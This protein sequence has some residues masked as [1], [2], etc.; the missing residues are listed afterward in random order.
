MHGTYSLLLRGSTLLAK[1]LYKGAM[2]KSESLKS[3]LQWL[4]HKFN[5][6]LSFND[7]NGITGLD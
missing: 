6:G 4:T 5:F 2:L 1:V 3:F 7:Y